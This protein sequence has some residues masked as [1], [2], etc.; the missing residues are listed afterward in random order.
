MEKLIN[1]LYFA[2]DKHKDQRRKGADALPYI[3]HPIAVAHLLMEAGINDQDLLCA[4][5]LH[6]VIEDCDVSYIDLVRKFGLRVA[7]IVLEVSDNPLAAN[8]KL[9]QI[10]K[11]KK[12]SREAKLIKLA[13]KICNVR[14]VIISPPVRWDAERKNKYIEF[15]KEI[16]NG[17]YGFNS[18]LDLVAV[19]LLEVKF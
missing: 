4:A 5:L 7:D 18:F 1:A 15:S 11:I 16:C 14:D 10:A 6:D 3:N 19:Q 8:R 2:A 17:A 13:D 9:E 12:I